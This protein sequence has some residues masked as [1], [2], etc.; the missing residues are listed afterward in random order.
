MDG[1]GGVST[2]KLHWAQQRAHGGVVGVRAREN[3]LPSSSTLVNR[4]PKSASPLVSRAQ[5]PQWNALPVARRLEAVLPVGVDVLVSRWR[6]V[7]DVGVRERVF[8]ALL[9]ATAISAAAAVPATAPIVAPT[10]TPTGPKD[11]P[12]TAPAAAPGFN[13]FGSVYATGLLRA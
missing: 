1:A 9:I 11:A 5:R 3:G 8:G 13:P 7:G 4:V 6:E 2:S 12:A 10:A